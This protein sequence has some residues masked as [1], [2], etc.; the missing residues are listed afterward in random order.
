MEEIKATYGKMDPGALAERLRTVFG[1]D[2]LCGTGL[3]V[4][5]GDSRI[6]EFANMDTNPQCQPDFLAS[7][8]DGEFALSHKEEFDVVVASH[9]LEHTSHPMTAVYNIHT[10]LKP[11][12]RLLA[13]VPHAWSD[14]GLCNPLHRHYFT[15]HTFVYF[16]SSTYN[17]PG[18]AGW[19]ANEGYPVADW[20]KAEVGVAP[21]PEWGSSPRIEFASKHYLNTMSEVYA[22]LT[23]RS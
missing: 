5:C 8:D 20:L 11:G 3:N 2:A 9:V 4:G 23:K 16:L 15:P 13:V 18:T 6:L 21:M 14:V 22:I 1:P 10:M 7:L 12:G 19:G 17:Q